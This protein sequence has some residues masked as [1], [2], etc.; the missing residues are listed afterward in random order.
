VQRCRNG[1]RVW[2]YRAHQF[3][4]KV[5]AFFAARRRI[6]PCDAMGELKERDDRYSD[7]IVTRF[8]ENRF[9][10]LPDIPASAFG[11]NGGGRV[12]DQSQAGGASG[13]R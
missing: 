10:Q 11:G 7:V 5:M 4:Q 9:Q 1:Y 3:V 6:G 12:E 2:W 8:G 13:S